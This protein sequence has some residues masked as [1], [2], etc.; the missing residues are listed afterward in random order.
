MKSYLQPI[1]MFGKFCA[2]DC[3]FSGAESCVHDC[4]L[5]GAEVCAYDCACSGAKGCY[6]FNSPGLQNPGA[7]S[8]CEPLVGA[9]ACEGLGFKGFGFGFRSL[10]LRRGG[11]AGPVKGL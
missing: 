1:L 9:A 3:A 11:G 2:H 5:S 6:R 10:S 8:A 7:H 4:A